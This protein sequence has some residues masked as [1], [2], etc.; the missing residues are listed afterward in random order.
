[1]KTTQEIYEAMRQAMAE[2]AGAAPDEGCELA[3]RL[4]AAAAQIESLY[5]YADWS[6]RQCFPQTAVGEELDKH[7][8]LRR[9][10][11]Q[12]G[13]REERRGRRPGLHYV[14]QFLLSVRQ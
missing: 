2:R 9:L 1:M 7:A 13:L 5:A 6:R 3:V 14:R 8:F 11:R 12:E 10:E 4:Y